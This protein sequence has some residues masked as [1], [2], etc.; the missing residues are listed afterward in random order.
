MKKILYFEGAGCVPRG[1]VENCR[2]RTAFHDNNGKA[3]YLEISGN[4]LPRDR[5]MSAW[6]NIN[7]CGYVHPQG[8][9]SA[10]ETI[11]YSDT[12]FEYTKANILRFVN[13][14]PHCSFDEIVVLPNSAG[15]RVHAD[16]GG[17]NFGDTFEYCPELTKRREEI[18]KHFYALEKREGKQYP[19]LSTWADEDRPEILHLLRHFNGYNRHWIIDVTAEDWQSTMTQEPLNS[20]GKR[21]VA[22]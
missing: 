22:K 3:I 7:Y 11:N 1:E 5:E 21:G 10:E 6:A 18:H 12:A 8:D 15:Y 14:L 16:R 19:N 17:F 4:D 20:P 9:W 2:I 13:R